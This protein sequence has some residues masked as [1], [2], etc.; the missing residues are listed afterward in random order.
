[1]CDRISEHDFRVAVAN[2]DTLFRL[3][4]ETRVRESV[5]DP[6]HVAAMHHF[7]V[8]MPFEGDVPRVKILVKEFSGCPVHT[9]G[10]SRQRR[11]R[12]ERRP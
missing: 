5:K 6:T 4:V 7:D 8:P 3:A 9:D 1:M 12:V 10:W 11:R 2:L